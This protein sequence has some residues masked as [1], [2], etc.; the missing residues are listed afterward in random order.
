MKL[1]GAHLNT[2]KLAVRKLFASEWFSRV[3]KRNLFGKYSSDDEPR[4]ENQLQGRCITILS[5]ATLKQTKARFS[6][7]FKSS[8]FQNAFRHVIGQKYYKKVDKQPQRSSNLLF[9]FSSHVTCGVIRARAQIKG[10]AQFDSRL[11]T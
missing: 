7:L 10:Y 2:S 8:K 1:F 5:L 3:N 9:S 4:T 6:A 11:R